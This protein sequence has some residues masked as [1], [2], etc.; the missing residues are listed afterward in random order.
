MDLESH[1]WTQQELDRRETT[2]TRDSKRRAS[3]P[4][5]PP[6]KSMWKVTLKLDANSKRR[7]P[8]YFAEAYGWGVRDSAEDKIL[9]VE[10]S[11]GK[12]SVLLSAESADFTNDSVVS[13]DRLPQV[14]SDLGAYRRIVF[15]E[16]HLGI[17]ESGSVVG[18][19]RQFRL[20][21]LALGLGI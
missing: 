14:C 3:K 9:A 15:D 19:A 16:Q 20:T 21:G 12:G 4:A 7:H 13:L 1:S 18:M 6:L 10:R 5:E 2:Q 11:F 8:L 17:A